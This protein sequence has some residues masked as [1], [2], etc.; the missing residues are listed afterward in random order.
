MPHTS[1]LPLI[2]LIAA[3]A[4]SALLIR[5]MIAVAV[6]DTPG[7]RSAHTRPTPKG[8][9]IGVIGAFLIFFVPLRLVCHL[10]PFT[11]DT[12]GLM[13]AVAFLALVSW[14]D[15]VWQ[16]HPLIKLA[17][18]IGAALL[19]TATTLPMDGFG[20]PALATAVAGGAVFWLVFVTNAVNFMD[21]LNGLVSGALAIAFLCLSLPF[22]PGE[23]TSLR[24]I[25]ALLTFGLL[26]FLPFNFPVARIFLGDVGSQ[27]CGLLIGAAALFL[28][29]GHATLLPGDLHAALLVPCLIAGLLW[30]VSFTLVRRAL[31][32]ETILQAHR[33]H[34]YQVA[35]RS[36]ISMPAVSLTHWG[37]VLWG[38]ASFALTRTMPLLTLLLV[39]A[40]QLAW[41]LF[42]IHRT[43]TH[44][45]GKW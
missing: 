20:S 18:Q 3:A 15:D 28:A 45:V 37:F 36:G 25:A 39:A 14:L 30:D 6:L 8:G 22:W 44:P 33:G 16:W 17:A 10:P 9:G 21:G 19:V 32:G 24:L 23:D 35:W 13:I 26:A 41:T 1:L 31:A 43:R 38:A 12:T 5:R 42:V 34:L 11:P 4:T 2:L 27:P 40:Q 7:H 29:T